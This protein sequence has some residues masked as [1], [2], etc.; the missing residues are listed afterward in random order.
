[1]EEI[2]KDTTFK[3]IVEI[4]PI[5]IKF[6]QKQGFE[7]IVQGD[8]IWGTIEEAAKVKDW[9]DEEVDQL[10]IELNNLL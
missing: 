7:C 10:V 4:Y 3:E 5:T 1:M 6:L 2:T 9:R 8:P